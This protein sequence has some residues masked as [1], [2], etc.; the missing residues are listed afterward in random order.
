MI[1]NT[2]TLDRTF[3]IYLLINESSSSPLVRVLILQYVWTLFHR[4]VNH[5]QLNKWS[6][7]LSKLPLYDHQKHHK[8]FLIKSRYSQPLNQIISFI[9]KN[10][11]SGLQKDFSQLD[12]NCLEAR[13]SRVRL[14]FPSQS[15]IGRE[16]IGN[17]IWINPSGTK[18]QEILKSW[19]RGTG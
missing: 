16:R 7:I 5:N 4:S 13:T 11:S 15:L 14:Y 6:S 9:N 10:R 19:N 12:R 18:S 8:Q 1:R 2:D 17:W 3:V